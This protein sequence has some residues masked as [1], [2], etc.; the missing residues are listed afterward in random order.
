MIENSIIFLFTNH[1]IMALNN[2]YIIIIVK[3]I[4]QI[5]QSTARQKIKDNYNCKP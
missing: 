3:D 2:N 1:D 5:S 4:Y